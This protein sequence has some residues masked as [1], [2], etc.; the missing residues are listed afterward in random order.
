MQKLLK[1]LFLG[2][3]PFSTILLI[4]LLVN[5][6]LLDWKY[7]HKSLMTYQKPFN[8]A[9]Y[10]M[11]IGFFKFI[12]SIS[13]EDKLG[14][15]KINLYIGEKSQKKLLHNV[16]S[17]TKIWQNAY[18][19]NIDNTLKKIKV[20]HRGDNPRN[21]LFEKKHYRI[22]TRKDD[23]FDRH[24]YFN[25][26]P[27]NL[28]KFISGKI[29]N[30]LN[31]I[32]P[33]YNL[34]EL[35]INEESAG[36]YIQAEKINENFLRRNKFMPVNIYKGE[37][38]FSES[39]INTENDLFNNKLT[40]KKIAYFNKLKKNN[41]DDL[42]YLLNLL[43][44]SENNKK[45]F[46]KIKNKID[47]EEWSKFAAYQILT[48]NYHNDSSH[49]M[50][51]IIDPWT[52][53]IFPIVHD[54]VIGSNIYNNKT[55]NL[56]FSSHALLLLLNKNSFF[57]DKKYE[58]LNKFLLKDKIL[59]KQVNFLSDIENDISQSEKRDIELQRSFYKQFNFKDILIKNNKIHNVGI[60]ERNQ[61]KNKFKDH[62]KLLIE[63]FSKKANANWSIKNEK[64]NIT[65]D[66]DL[67]ISN[68][69][70]FFDSKKSNWVSIDIN[71]NKIIEDSEKFF[72]NNN[73][74]VII[75][76]KLYANRTSLAKYTYALN[77]PELITSNTRFIINSS[78]NSIPIKII[79]E[80]PFTKKNYEILNKE[81]KSIP[82]NK[83][84]MPLLNNKSLDSKLTLKGTIKINNDTVFNDEIVIEPGTNFLMGE[85]KSIIFK[86][87]I[88]AVGTQSNPITFK[89]IKSNNNLKW[90]TV[91]LY[92]Q[93]TKDS[94]L[95]NLIIKDG[96]GSVIDNV[97]FT[98]MLSIHDTENIKLINIKMKNNFFYDDA[99]HLVYCNNVIIDNLSIENANS[100]ALD[101]DISENILIQNSKFNNSKNDSIDIMESTVLID[102]TK[103]LKSGDKGVSI[104]ENS[105]VLIINSNIIGNKIGIATKD[106][107]IAKV[108]YSNFE[109]NDLQIDAYQKNLQYGNGGTINVY[110][111]IFD[112]NTNIIN[113]DSASIIIIED[114]SFNNK[115]KFNDKNISISNTDFDGSK[116]SKMLQNY[117]IEHPLID[118]ID[119]K[120]NKKS[121]G[122][123]L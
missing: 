88:T 56:E 115:L 61:L 27:Y 71:Q 93:G 109:T 28:S 120:N 59:H 47:L 42:L 82:P 32:S 106:K 119:I 65:V 54:P 108:L 97:Y 85:G 30:D 50:R 81:R 116:I 77:E 89:S 15:N 48:Q 39:I 113:S 31:L 66:G 79:V 118:Y 103:L 4:L 22:K 40:W 1:I 67:P 6:T 90:G 20:R 13:K 37:Q 101:I 3:I 117:Y 102:S 86:K 110:K 100:D 24:R 92:G 68:I 75:P 80:N 122:S 2:I 107:S 18:Y 69:K 17:S 60:N 104:G 9:L 8:W 76:V 57:I 51:I 55:Q 10:K 25:F 16:P 73:Y 41:K 14:L 43:R 72:L 11:E 83:F 78:N 34:V 114:S 74:E 62:E 23:Q 121:R 12:R 19:L 84:N 53:K 58:Q 99:L 26:L 123:D 45:S 49:N 33:K 7:A 105:N 70:L 112:A 38:I 29:S 52:G 46:Q 5:I 98:S 63:K 44:E 21:W 111:S 96:S 91:A 94:I 87:K 35:F 64:I 95:K 36:V